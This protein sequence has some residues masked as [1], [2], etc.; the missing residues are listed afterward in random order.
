MQESRGY[1][2]DDDVDGDGRID[3]VRQRGERIE[4]YLQKPRA[5]FED[6]PSLAWDL[7]QDVAL[8]SFAPLGD[9]GRR[10]VTFGSEGVAIV[11]PSKGR[12]NASS[13]TLWLVHEPLLLQRGD[14]P[15]RRGT[16]FVQW[17]N[18]PVGLL[19]VPRAEGWT[20][21]RRAGPLAYDRC[22]LLPTTVQP[23]LGRWVNVEIPG[24]NNLR[25]FYPGDSKRKDRTLR[26]GEETSFYHESYVFADLD[27]DGR[28]EAVSEWADKLIR[29]PDERGKYRDLSDPFEVPS[30]NDETGKVEVSSN[31]RELILGGELVD[32]NG[33]GI[34]DHLE[35]KSDSSEMNPRTEFRLFLGEK[36]FKIAQEPAQTL[37]IGALTI[38]G[39]ST[40]LCDLNRD[41]MLDLAM[42]WLDI[43]PYSPQEA[44][45]DFLDQ[46]IDGELRFFLYRKGKGWPSRP[47]VTKKVRV[48]FDL[49]G[50]NFWGWPQV[51]LNQDFDGDGRPDLAVKT[52]KQETQI[53]LQ[54]KEKTEFENQPAA[55]VKTSHPFVGLNCKD[56]NADGRDDLIFF[57]YYEDD[58]DF[59]GLEV[60]F[61]RAAENGGKL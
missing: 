4:V 33:D 49:F 54:R 7:P 24:E 37:R 29:Q 31:I 3:F 30:L 50:F 58:R 34:L 18:D 10:F 39:F 46:G 43:K 20:L 5:G 59:S 11:P 56:L 47:D 8:F 55:R 28:P 38:P 27:G 35:T 16:G 60:F 61:S 22:D 6:A 42:I 40:P 13:Q 25:S 21:H 52:N 48:S 53:F 23:R 45:R 9:K 12:D 44:V 19:V 57:T 17:E 15:L 14:L 32:V 1:W 2:F 26:V 36:P 51:S 41:G